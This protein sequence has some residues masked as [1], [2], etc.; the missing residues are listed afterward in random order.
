MTKKIVLFLN[1]I[2]VLSSE[3]YWGVLEAQKKED[4]YI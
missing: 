2:I 4:S 1:C 3:K